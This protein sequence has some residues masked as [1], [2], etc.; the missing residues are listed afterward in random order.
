MTNVII[1]ETI[2]T[3]KILNISITLHNFMSLLI[4]PLPS[5]LS[6][7]FRKSL[8]CFLSLNIS[9]HFLELYTNLVQYGN[10]TLH[11]P[12]CLTSLTPHNY[13]KI[14][15][16]CGMCQWLILFIA[17]YHFIVR[18]YHILFIYSPNDHMW[19]VSSFVLLQKILL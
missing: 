1:C 6:L 15:A 13:F 2:T 9:L 8:K 17:K 5:S 3:I 18:L 4:F 11:T 19:T 12:F 16:C 10:T 7:T 14:F